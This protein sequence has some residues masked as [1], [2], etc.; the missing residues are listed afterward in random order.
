MIEILAIAS[1]IT[2]GAAFVKEGGSSTG[3]AITII[4]CIALLLL[5]LI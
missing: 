3:K 5:M 4:I 1:I 2:I